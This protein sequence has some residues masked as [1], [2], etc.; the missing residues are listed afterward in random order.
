MSAS[1]SDYTHE[2]IAAFARRYGLQRLSDEHLARMRE[3]AAYVSDLGREL[4]RPQHKDDPPATAFDL[5]AHAI[6]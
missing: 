1:A 5:Q 2:E 4:P 6:R 3:L